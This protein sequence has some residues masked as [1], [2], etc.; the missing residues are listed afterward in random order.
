MTV[1]RGFNFLMT[2]GPTNIPGR[3]LRAMHRPAIEFQGHEFIEYSRACH[4]DIKPLFQTKNEVFIYSANGHGAWEAA[5]TNTLSTGDRVLVPETGQFSLSWMEMAETLGITGEYLTNDWRH[6]IDPDEVETRLVDDKDREIKA[7]LAVQ[8]DTATGI[9]SDIAAVR[10][11]MDAADHP[12]LLMVDTVASLVTTEFRMDEWGVDVAVG[13]SQ[14]GMMMPPGLSFTAA[15]NKAQKIG[16][17]AN[18]PRNYWD[19][20]KRR[21]QSHYT[22]YCGTAPEHLI[23]GLRE[24]IDMV[25]EEGLEGAHR[26][27]QWLASAVR[28][29]VEVW[30][31]AGALELNAVVEEQK[32]NSISTILVADD[33]DVEQIHT[34]CRD[35]FDV[36]LGYGLGQLDGRSFR[37]GHMGYVNAPMIIATLGCIETVFGT[38]GIPHGKGGIMAALDSLANDDAVSA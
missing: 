10:L 9:T 17:T 15:S 20:R 22:W 29:A 37:I 33:I 1:R 7:V 16:E 35:H 31:K 28:A 21:G 19:W 26:R 32:S 5:L 30:A 38:C 4:Q 13:G 6:G 8:T 23:F 18:L 34:V 3:I 11:A 2:P 14:K 24:A 12:A 36:A 25:I 27:H